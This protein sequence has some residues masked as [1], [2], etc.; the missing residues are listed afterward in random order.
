M[1]NVNRFRFQFHPKQYKPIF[2]QTKQP[3]TITMSSFLTWRTVTRATRAPATSFAP[4]AFSTTFVARK[5]A[6]ESVKD[7]VK[8][9]DRKVSD[10]LVEGIEVG[11]TAAQKAKEVAGMSSSEM[12]GKANEVARPRERQTRLLVR[13]RERRMSL[14]ARRKERRRKYFNYFM[15]FKFMSFQS[16][17][18][19]KN[20]SHFS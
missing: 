20:P 15:R 1:G 10:V 4:R 14:Q 13:L 9:V 5:S 7:G 16:V 8:T 17:E 12:K 19:F 2:L 18:I 6:T 11:Q 3:T